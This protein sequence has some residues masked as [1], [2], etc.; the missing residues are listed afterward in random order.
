ML[1]SMEGGAQPYHPLVQGYSMKRMESLGIAPA[2]YAPLA[3]GHDNYVFAML[4]DYHRRVND[5]PDAHFEYNSP[6]AEAAGRQWLLDMGI[7]FPADILTRGYAS[8]LRSLRYADAYTP[9]FTQ[10]P[11]ALHGLE[12]VH[13]RF[14]TFMH[15]SGLLLGLLVL[16]IIGARSVTAGLGLIIFVVY[17]FGYVGL[18]CEFRH[19]FHL[20]FI[21]FWVMGFLANTGFNVVRFQ[22]GNSDLTPPT[23]WRTALFHML[24]FILC[25]A[26]LVIAPLEILHLYQRHKAKAVIDP[27]IAAPVM[28]VN[29]VKTTTHGWAL[30]SLDTDSEKLTSTEMVPDGLTELQAL[31]ICL[32]RLMEHFSPK[33]LM[34]DTRARL[35]MVELDSSKMPEWLYIRYT[36]KGAWNDFS[37]VVH[38]PAVTP[39]QGAVRHY[40]PVYEIYMPDD[41]VPARN[42][43]V[44]IGVP[45]DYA[46]SVIQICQ[47]TDVSDIRFLLHLTTTLSGEFLPLY[48]RVSFTPDPLQYYLVENDPVGIGTMGE[49]AERMGREEDAVFFY[50]T[51]Q[52]LS[53]DATYRLHLS[54]K[55]LQLNLLQEALVMVRI[56]LR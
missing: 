8:V 40:F 22:R 28:S 46:D 18:Q 23:A 52:L 31:A 42:A 14:A 2:A 39:D 41:Q 7:H 1:F 43:F 53:T 49:S 5:A 16:L 38:L 6:G 32:A 51:A 34:W 29:T 13:L 35:M 3:S 50:C 47:V 17:V 12:A 20:A 56:L 37:Q 33:P 45:E 4:Y 48:Q 11:P 15:C 26:I 24:V 44:G 19:A 54:Q 36:S 55:L 27:I 9:W 25:A 30:F 10:L 21:P